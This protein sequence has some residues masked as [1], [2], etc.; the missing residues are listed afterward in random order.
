MA[1]TFDLIVIGAGSAARD[2]AAKASREHGA[3]VALIERT[4]W[5]GSCP[6]VAC[7]PTKAYLVAAELAYT[8]NELSDWMGVR[9]GPAEVDL[10]RVRA[11]KDSIRRS[12]ESWQEVL[13][14]AGYELFPGEA[15]FVDERTLRVGD[16]ELTAD[17]ILVATGSRTAVPPVPGIED[18]D[19]IDHIGA[20]E[21][22]EIPES[23]LVVGAGPVGLE[24]A[25]IFARFGS[26]VTIVNHGPQIAA[27]AD[28]EAAGELQA[29]L[30]DEGIDVILDAGVE[31]FA[32]EGD[33]T[34]VTLP[35]HILGVT[36]VLLAS[37]RAPNTDELALDR[38]GVETDRGYVVVDDRQRTTADGIWAAGDVAI[39]PQFT[40]AAQY[41]ARIAIED[42]FDSAG[43]R[44][45]NYTVMPTAIFTDPELGAV[46]LTE[47]EARAAGH[48][49]DVVKHPLPN[50]TR[51]QYTRSK[52]GLFKIVFD[53][54]SRRVLGVHVVS[55]GASD[56]VGGLAPALQLGVT[57]DD[58][59]YMHHV[60]PSY[61]EGLKAAAEKAL[62]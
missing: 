54:A 19:W 14:D 23:L 7:R 51:A 1:D 53:T 25:Q 28:T 9:C 10:A 44:R 38:A 35:D 22:E 49:V 20:L 3:R 36:H 59:A 16:R 39:G 33:L 8:V 45:A 12:Q 29:A 13:A 57:V 46:G 55:R 43:G 18:V 11:W 40:P 37:G 26:K 56:I 2:G 6:N 60:Y 34:V 24:F 5:G 31:S 47:Q 50:V 52:H 48:E 42:M 58:I 4:R 27:R 30:V 61:S 32:R 17:R 21:L 15:S 41:Q 62:A